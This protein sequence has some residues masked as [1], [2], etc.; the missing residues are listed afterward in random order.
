MSRFVRVAGQV[1]TRLQ[2]QWEYLYRCSDWTD[3]YT[4]GITF[5][6]NFCEFDSIKAVFNGLCLRCDCAPTWQIPG[7]YNSLYNQ[8]MCCVYCFCDYCRRMV[9]IPIPNTVVC[10]RSHVDVAPCQNKFC[11][12]TMTNQECIFAS[13]TNHEIVF[14]PLSCLEIGFSAMNIPNCSCWFPGS[15]LPHSGSYITCS[16]CYRQQVSGWTRNK[17]LTLC[18]RCG[19]LPA[20]QS[21]QGG[22]NWAIYGQYKKFQAD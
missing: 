14:T 13:V 15:N 18:D 10:C 19:I 6:I 1:D 7:Y 4:C 16:C 12:Q 17:K 3:C 11:C 9:C 8:V 5:D 22:S 2:T 20:Q 21:E